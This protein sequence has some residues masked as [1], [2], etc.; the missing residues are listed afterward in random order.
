MTMRPPKQCKADIVEALGSLDVKVTE[1]QTQEL[2][3]QVSY[4]ECKLA[5]RFSKNG[6]APGLDGIQ[7]EV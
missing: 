2:V 5:L 4:D 1:E 6:T 3:A 7:Y